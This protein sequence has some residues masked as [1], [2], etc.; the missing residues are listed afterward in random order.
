MFWCKRCEEHCDAFFKKGYIVI[1]CF[2]LPYFYFLFRTCPVW[3]ECARKDCNEVSVNTSEV[4]FFFF[5]FCK[6]LFMLHVNK[7]KNMEG[8]N[9]MY[10]IFIL[11]IIAVSVS[12]KLADT[13]QRLQYNFGRRQKCTKKREKKQMWWLPLTVQ[14]H[15]ITVV[16]PSG[17]SEV[18]KVVFIINFYIGN[19]SE[20][21]F[22]ACMLWRIYIIFPPSLPLSLSWNVDSSVFWVTFDSE[23]WPL[24]DVLLSACFVFV[25]LFFSSHKLHMEVWG[26]ERS[27]C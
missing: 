3:L 25:C 12:K 1:S 5:F 23:W 18:L 24:A 26:Q 19:I 16:S 10:S 21:K 11:V 15:A 6:A 4:I 22:F 14:H 7:P 27:R 20:K 8:A 17:Q 2:N 13:D 9:C